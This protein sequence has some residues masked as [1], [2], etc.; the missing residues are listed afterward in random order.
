MIKPATDLAKKLGY[1]FK[2]SSLIELALTHRSHGKRNNERLEFLGDSILNFV[3]A[4]ALY[5]RFPEAKEG[6]LSR[7][8][9]LLV[10]GETLAELAREMKLGDYLR[11]G[12]GELKSGGFRRDSILAD[13]VEAIIG[14]IY[15]DSDMDTCRPYILDWYKSRLAQT[16][17]EDTQKD[18]KTRLQEFLQSRRAPLPA[19][20][21]IS[22]TGEAHKQTF[23]IRCSVTLLDQPTDGKGNSRR[24]AEQEAARKALESLKVGS[25]A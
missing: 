9:A 22:V 17:L 16:S 18:S 15:M 20:E 7:L 10:K 8:R 19:Y 25:T 12:S 11:L 24:Q 23:E 6:Q 14:A 1:Q 5:N 2:D 4:E 13:A 3:I 21:L